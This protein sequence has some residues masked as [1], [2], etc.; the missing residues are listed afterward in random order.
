M[1][2][3]SLFITLSFASEPEVVALL[4]SVDVGRM[5]RLL[6]T[7]VYRDTSLPYDNSISNLRNRYALNPVMSDTLEGVPAVLA[8]MLREAMPRAKIRFL[9]FR[10]EGGPTLY[11][12]S[13][14]VPGSG[15]GKFL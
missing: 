11:N 12:I 10:H 15:P 1:L 14:V 5:E 6:R 9:P 2:A 7:L 3:L 8:R 4:D 13:A